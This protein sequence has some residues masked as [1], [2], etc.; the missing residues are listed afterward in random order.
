[1]QVKKFE[2]SS[3][4][5][6]LH[7]VKRDLGPDAII[8]STQETKKSITGQKMFTVVAAVT[9]SQFKKKEMAQQ[10]LGAIFDERVQPQSAVRQKAFIENVYHGVERAHQKRNQVITQTPYIDID[11]GQSEAPM[12][13]QAPTQAPNQMS[14]PQAPVET[15]ANLTRVKQAARDAFKSSLNS[16]FFKKEKKTE[17]SALLPDHMLKAIAQS[18]NIG[19]L[20]PEM[21]VSMI[22][23]LNQCGVSNEICDHLQDLAIREL[24]ANSNRKA[25]VDAWFAK[26]I[27][28]RVKVAEAQDSSQVE[29]FVGPHG[30]GKTSALVKLATHHVINEQKSVAIITCDLNK[31]GGVEQLRVFS[32]ILNAPVYVAQ[33]VQDIEAQLGQ[34]QGYDKVF[35]DTPGISLSN[36]QELDFMRS[37]AQC[38]TSLKKR[39]HLVISALTKANDLGGVLKRFRVAEFDDLVVT[40]IDQ[41][42]QH[43]VL[44]NIQEKIDMPFH[45]FG[46]GS[47]I[48][49]GFEFASRERVLDLIFKLTKRSGDRANDSRI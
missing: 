33:N 1:M 10:K 34:L 8:L 17:D 4:V 41:T 40:N 38:N 44:L 47:D 32:R 14:A 29:F 43:G 22:Q 20:A 23:R 18:K 45:S 39:T 26:W 13:A 35:I 9:D 27:L 36:M 16:E 42:S 5:E 11:D 7:Q 49:D 46:I 24:G 15:T 6:A 30:A 3:V 28:N 31:V 21:I 2:A 25:V 19:P 12:A 37:V 48:V